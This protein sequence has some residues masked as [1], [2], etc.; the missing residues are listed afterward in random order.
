MFRFG[1]AS[2]CVRVV[3]PPATFSRPMRRHGFGGQLCVWRTP[4]PARRRK[5][6]LVLPSSQGS[7]RGAV[8]RPTCSEPRCRSSV[9]LRLGRGLWR[10]SDAPGAPSAG[11][12][13][14][15]RA[16]LARS[17]RLCVATVRLLAFAFPQRPFVM[18]LA[19]SRA[20]V[21][22][23]GRAVGAASSACV[24]VLLPATQRP[25]RCVCGCTAT[26][27]CSVCGL[28]ERARRAGP[29]GA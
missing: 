24:C 20:V 10:P 7:F 19:R 9:P 8:W 5:L 15:C 28:W 3:E 13:L 12:P 29:P 16:W 23:R 1:R 17:C 2:R 6:P 18:L 26:W 27:E 11:A 4:S 14:G 22:A 25:L 21:A